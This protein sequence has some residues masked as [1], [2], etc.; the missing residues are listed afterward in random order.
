[1]CVDVSL[2]YGGELL[3]DTHEQMSSSSDPCRYHSLPAAAQACEKCRVVGYSDRTVY[4]SLA[5]LFHIGGL[6]STLAVTMAGGTH[7]FLPRMD[8]DLA[9]SAMATCRYTGWW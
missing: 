4:L 8:M 9:A 6:S 1:M 5:P 2:V 3:H 7:V